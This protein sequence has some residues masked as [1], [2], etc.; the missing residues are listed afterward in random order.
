MA[1]VPEVMGE[2]EIPAAN[3]GPTPL[4]PSAMVLWTYILMVVLM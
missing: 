3:V 1:L 4:F 2:K